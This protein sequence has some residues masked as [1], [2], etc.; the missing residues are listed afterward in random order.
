MAEGQELPILPSP[1]ASRHVQA[2]PGREVGWSLPGWTRATQWAPFK[3]PFANVEAHV[4]EKC[5]H[6]PT[7]NAGQGGGRQ[8]SDNLHLG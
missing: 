5:Y 6:L 8:S 1:V 7:T 4:T 2:V 3:K